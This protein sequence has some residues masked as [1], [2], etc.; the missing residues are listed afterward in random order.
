MSDFIAST[1]PV[2]WGIQPDDWE[3]SWMDKAWCSGDLRS[4]EHPEH[5]ARVVAAQFRAREA[6]EAA[7]P[8]GYNKRRFLV[9]CWCGS[10]VVE[11]DP[12]LTQAGDT[13]VCDYYRCAQ[14]A[15]MP[16]AKRIKL[17]PRNRAARRDARPRV[18]VADTAAPHVPDPRGLGS[19]RAAVST[20]THRDTAASAPAVFPPAAGAVPATAR[21]KQAPPPAASPRGGVCAAPVRA[22]RAV[23]PTT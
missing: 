16:P 4:P 12:E 7:Y 3:T 15:A 8:Q 20:P 6:P 19:G 18:M 11:A 23:H 5:G 13:V 17:R 1:I 22:A 10:L 9:Q 14:I 21:T 2:G